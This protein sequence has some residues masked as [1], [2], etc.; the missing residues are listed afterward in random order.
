NEIQVFYG[1]E[2][3]K[4]LFLEIYKEC[5]KNK[6][7]YLFQGR[8][9]EMMEA[10]GEGFYAY[11]Q[12]LKKKLK[13]QCRIILSNETRR[14]SYRKYTVGNIRYLPTKVYSPINFWIYGDVILLVLFRAS[15]LTII[16]IKSNLLSD[17][18]KNY[19]ESLWA[20]SSPSRKR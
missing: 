18:F 2:A 20:I 12:K 17:G 3:F 19:F 4:A 6:I 7:E 8:G 13:I 15:P 11:T 14:L 1:I 16:K 10:T 9:G 5:K